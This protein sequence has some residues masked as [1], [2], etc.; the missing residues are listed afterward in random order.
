MTISCDLTPKAIEHLKKLS[1]LNYDAAEGFEQASTRVSTESGKLLEMTARERAIFREE[2]DAVLKNFET[3]TPDSGTTLGS[4]H[5][6][7]MTARGTLSNSTE[8]AILSEAERG[9]A[10]LIEA[11]QEALLEIGA[12]EVGSMLHAQ[13]E[14]IR[15]VQ[16]GISELIRTDKATSQKG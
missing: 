15:K 1:R 7:W 14:A 8:E 3:E 10:V 5:R 13:L 2:I 9:E 4:L 11:Y 16:S 12:N 6:L